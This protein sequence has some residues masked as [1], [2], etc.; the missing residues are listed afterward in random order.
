MLA[1]DMIHYLTRG[2]LPD[3]DIGV[4]RKVYV[5]DFV[6]HRFCLPRG[7]SFARAFP[8]LGKS[9]QQVRLQLHPEL[10]LEVKRLVSTI[11]GA[12]YVVDG[13]LL[14]LKS[15]VSV[16]S[17]GPEQDKINGLRN[18]A[19]RNSVLVGSMGDATVE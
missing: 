12:G 14:P 11:Q 10:V 5:F 15:P 2:A 1:F 13:F 16:V 9:I 7:Y 4:T 19:R 17:L 18:V 6:T 3:I 8:T